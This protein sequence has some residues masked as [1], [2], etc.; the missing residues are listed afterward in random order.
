M[1]FN[2]VYS[3]VK[4]SALN[5]DWLKKEKSKDK[6]FALMRFFTREVLG[7]L[8]FILSEILTW[9]RVTFLQLEN[10]TEDFMRIDWHVF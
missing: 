5:T 6:I 9:W 4:S 2:R 1:Q 3:T 7:F 10:N 8:K